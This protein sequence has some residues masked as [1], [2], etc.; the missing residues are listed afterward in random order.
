MNLDHPDNRLEHVTSNHSIKSVQQRLVSQ[1]AK[2][3]DAALKRIDY[4]D[5][6]IQWSHSFTIR[7][8]FEVKED[9]KNKAKTPAK[10]PQKWLLQHQKRFSMIFAERSSFFMGSDICIKSPVIIK[11]LLP[12]DILIR[13]RKVVD[14]Q[15]K[16]YEIDPPVNEDVHEEELLA[17]DDQIKDTR[18]GKEIIYSQELET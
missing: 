7:Q 3:K 17:A 6:S 16:A 9:P 1:R 10:P 11:N 8:F 15:Y 18:S 14:Y 2:A 12:F 13:T 5:K 4:P